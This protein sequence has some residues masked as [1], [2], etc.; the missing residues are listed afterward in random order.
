MRLADFILS[1][2]EPILQEWEAFARGIAPGAK[3]D[4]LALRD[5]ADAILLA[6]VHDMKTSQSASQRA[7]KARGRPLDDAW[8][9]MG[10]RNCMRLEGSVRGLT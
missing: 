8:P 6:T 5:H 3:M 7:A 9:S 2:T 1:N 4:N 10:R